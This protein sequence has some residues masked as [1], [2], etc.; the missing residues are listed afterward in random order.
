MKIESALLLFKKLHIKAILIGAILSLSACGPEDGTS[1]VVR[2]APPAPTSV[3][4]QDITRDAPRNIIVYEE[5]EEDFILT[6]D[7]PAR[8]KINVGVMLPLSGD[9]AQVGQALLNAATMALFDASDKRLEII[10]VDT[11]GTPEG[12][13]LAVNRLIENNVDI[14]IGPLFSEN[15]KAVHPI[16][17]DAGIKIIGFSTDHDVAG[18]GVYLLSFRAEEQVARVVNYASDQRYEKF[19]ALIPDTLYGGRIMSVLEPLVAT[20]FN[21]LVA[22]EIY[23]SDPSMLDDPVKR[24]TNYDFRRQ[25]FLDEMSFLR[26]LGRNDDMGQEYINEIRN[27]EALGD[28]N[29]D[30]I[31]L[32]EGGSLLGSLA[33]LLS[34][35]EIDLSKVKV[36]GTGLWND[37]MLFN[38]PQLQGG[39]FASPDD[40]LATAFIERYEQAFSRTPPRIVTLGYDAMALIANIVR[41]QRAPTFSNRIMTN[42]DGFSGLDGIFRFHKSGLVERGLAIYEVTTEAFIKIDDAPKSFVEEERPLYVELPIDF[43][44]KFDP[45]FGLTA[46]VPSLRVEVDLDELARET[47]ELSRA[48]LDP[49]E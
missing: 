11:K 42:P 1:P 13:L 37:P 27:L 48:P 34:Y 17:K 18:E 12:S 9:T 14:I 39:W 40:E 20:K 2:S 35:Y 43:T 22:L 38:E 41:A 7:R 21:D 16:A 45:V 8:L 28:V 6:D 15:I 46:D 26:S 49:P 31:L 23:P 24:I 44:P 33:P 3:L 19:A 32:P 30:A 29:F 25:E 36:L 47:L 4:E 5:D 10:P